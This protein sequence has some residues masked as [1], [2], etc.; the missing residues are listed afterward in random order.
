METLHIQKENRIAVITIDRPDVLNAVNAAVVAELD[1]AVKD[2]VSDN[3]VGV[4]IITGSGEKAFV[5]GADIKAMSEMNSADALEFGKA[6]QAMTLT[7]E[8]SPKPVIAAV[9]GF[10]LG[11][12]CEIALACHIRIAAE[13]AVFSQP[14]VK[15]GLIPGWGGTQRLPRIVGKGKAN[16]MILTGEMVS[17]DEAY[18][19][20]LANAV[21]PQKDLLETCTNMAKSI[22]KNGPNAIAQSLA[23][24]N[25]GS[26]MPIKE[27][28][29]MEV[30][31]FSGLFETEETK[32]GLSAFVEKRPPKFRS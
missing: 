6:G 10:A 27:G 4:I 9:N 32:E 31:N 16:E 7:I 24:I 17:A 8:N 19:I 12:G 25:A 21:V 20:G 11:G 28:L 26:G 2:A 3:T 18:R 13:N 22:L 29:D 5:A 1:Q 30:K 15:I 14:E 23:S